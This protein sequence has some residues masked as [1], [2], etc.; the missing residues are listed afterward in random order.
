MNKQP[1]NFQI[2]FKCVLFEL[3]V[4]SLIFA[5]AR[6]FNRQ[7]ILFGFFNVE[8]LCCCSCNTE[9]SVKKDRRC[10]ITAK[11]LAEGDN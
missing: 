3:D 1:Q 5:Y 8:R 11:H 2:F 4:Q 10:I 9:P 7:S 6:L